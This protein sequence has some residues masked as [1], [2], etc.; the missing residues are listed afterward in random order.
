MCAS[1]FRGARADRTAALR[2]LHRQVVP[3]RGGA[4]ELQPS[5][6]GWYAALA[7]IGALNAAVSLYYYMR[8]AR[9]MFLDAPVGEVTVR[10]H[11]SYQ[12]MLGVFSVALVLFG[13]WWNPIVQWSQ[14][15]L[16]MLRG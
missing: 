10:P 12:I 8:V 6:R 7:I 11:R 5:R 14:Q 1:A 13:I 3:V 2:R 4:A 16:M 9:A 15:S